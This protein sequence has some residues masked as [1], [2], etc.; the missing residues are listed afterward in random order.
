MSGDLKGV[1][2][3][4]DSGLRLSIRARSGEAGSIKAMQVLAGRCEV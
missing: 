4:A 1:E 3:S 2:I